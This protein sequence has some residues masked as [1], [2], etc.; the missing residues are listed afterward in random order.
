[1]AGDHSVFL[2]RT[3]SSRLIVCLVVESLFTLTTFTACLCNGLRA[4]GL[5][6]ILPRRSRSLTI[7]SLDDFLDARLGHNHGSDMHQPDSPGP[8]VHQ[9]EDL[10]SRS[11]R[12]R[13]FRAQQHAHKQ[14]T[15]RPSRPPASLKAVHLLSAEE[16]KSLFH[17]V[18]A[19]LAFLVWET[20]L[21]RSWILTTTKA[22]EDHIA[23]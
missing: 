2:V 12:I 9:P 1:M 14:G 3:E 7:T 19:G 6:Y 23:S 13:A 15:L 8:D 20:F 4:G 10:R 18:T 16:V 22:R 11:T 17:D 5:S 21:R